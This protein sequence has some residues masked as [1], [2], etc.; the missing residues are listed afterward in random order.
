MSYL[1]GHWE[2]SNDYYRDRLAYDPPTLYEGDIDARYYPDD[3]S[4]TIQLAIVKRVWRAM[5]RVAVGKFKDGHPIEHELTRGSD[6]VLMKDVGHRNPWI[7]HWA[8][9]WCR[10]GAAEGKRRMLCGSYRPCDDWE[11]PSTPVYESLGRIIDEKY[12]KDFGKGPPE[13]TD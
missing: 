13:P 9:Q 2:W 1:R 12:G 4:H 10:D 6:V 5:A 7:G 3:P 11:M 8:L